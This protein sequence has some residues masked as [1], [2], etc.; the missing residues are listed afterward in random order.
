MDDIIVFNTLSKEHLTL[1][2][3]IQLAPRECSCLKASGMRLEVTQS[4]KDVLMTEGYDPA[5]R[6]AADAAGDPAA[7]SG[8]A[9]AAAAQRRFLGG[10]TV[11]V[12]GNAGQARAGIHPARAGAGGDSKDTHMHSGKH[13]SRRSCCSAC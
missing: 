2:I 8:S 3:D 4:A 5:L 9:L 7:D 10:D 12:E 13:A 11:V 1:I 6:S